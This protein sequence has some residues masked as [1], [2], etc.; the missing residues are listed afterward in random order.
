MS[1]AFTTL[2]AVAAP[3]P[4]PN[5]D[6]DAILPARFLKRIE[7]AGLG[8]ALFHE[9]RYAADG[10]ERPEFVLNQAPYR[11]ARILVAGAN[12]G[13]GSSR[14]NAVWALY[15]HGI[16]CVIAPSFGDIFYNNSVN[17]GLLAVV[18]E[19]A[20]VEALSA[21]LTAKPGTRLQVDLPAQCVRAP[22]LGPAGFAI[23]AHAKHRLLHG[24]DE[25][26]LTL[27]R[28]PEI[29]A[30]EARRRKERPWLFAD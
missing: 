8:A 5:V 21:L 18:L 29:A 13:C 10:K 16:R 25:I 19:P 22:G 1:R 6:T 30:Y 24:L 3:L 4:Q 17:Y 7:V 27:E 23:A 26:A 9:W 14:E 2:E 15:D 11:D 20:R 28:E 12:F